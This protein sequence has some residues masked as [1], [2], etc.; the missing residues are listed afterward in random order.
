MRQGR[1][2]NTAQYVAFNRALGNLAPEVKGFSDPVAR[3]FLPARWQR[4][5]SKKEKNND[6]SP[7]PFWVS[8]GMAVFNQFRTVVLDDAIDLDQP[9]PQLVILGAG[10]DGRAYRLNCLQNTI[11]FEVDHPNTQKL[12]KQRSEGLLPASR[13]IRHVGMDFS[14]DDLIE[15]LIENGHDPLIPTFWLWE[16]V[17]MYLDISDIRETMTALANVSA[18]GSRLALTYMDKVEFSFGQKISITLFGIMTGEPMCSSF[19]MTEIDHLAD[20]T[21]WETI[22][23]TGIADW[24]EELASNISLS[25]KDVGFQ[26]DE[27][28]WVGQLAQ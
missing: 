7:Y 6:H 5:I 10:M 12:K 20:Y 15:K 11:V 3:N 25:R 26:W 27:R 24:K 1:P 14:R 19:T 28:I 21:G 2:S 23:N 17:T 8:H 4:L 22:S 9:S 16:G 18:P 13:E